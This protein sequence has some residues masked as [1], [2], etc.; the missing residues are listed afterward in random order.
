MPKREDILHSVLIV[1]GSEQFTAV[2]RKALPSGSFAAI[3]IRKSAAVARRSIL[4]R[5]YD[6]VVINV[7]LP[8][9]AGPEFALDVSEKCNASILLAVPQEV[10]D[11]TLEHVADAGIQVLAK[12]F[13]GIRMNQAVRSMMAV[14][15]KFRQAEKKIL[16]VQE[17]M[18]ELRIVSKAKCLLI[19]K[20]QMTEEEAHRYIGKQAM[21]HGI[22]RKR[23]AERILEDLE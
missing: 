15:R 19:E 11:E 13:S 6:I 12:P 9:E 7:P 1:S 23:S 10:C 21:D 4:E 16:S 5:Y 22:S 17:K 18:E 14:Q 3:D 20:K 8:D 2:T